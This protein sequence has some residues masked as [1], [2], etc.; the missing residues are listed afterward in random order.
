MI[1]LSLLFSTRLYLL[2]SHRFCVS[3]LPSRRFNH[4]YA[5]PPPSSEGGEA[6]LC[7]AVRAQLPL[8]APSIKMCRHRR[9]SKAKPLR[10]SRGG[11]RRKPQSLPCRAQGSRERTPSPLC[12]IPNSEFRI[13]HYS[14][15][16][17]LQNVR[18]RRAHLHFS[19]AQ[20]ARFMR[21]RRASCA[22]GALHLQSKKPAE[23]GF[24]LFAHISLQ[25]TMSIPVPRTSCR[26]TSPHLTGE[27]TLILFISSI[28]SKIFSLGM[29]PL[30]LTGMRG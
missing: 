28:T 23:A 11:Y 12:E 19:C 14:V 5:V 25:A 22:G 10:G 15:P 3:L 4:L 30:V 16:P 2:L 6:A 20:R 26:S 29:S 27:V 1:Q 13:P 18:A 8:C 17:P 24:L 9:R 21:R 7:A